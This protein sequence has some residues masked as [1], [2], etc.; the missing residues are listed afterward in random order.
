MPFLTDTLV[1]TF[2]NPRMGMRRILDLS[3]PRGGA[4]AALVLMAVASAMLIHLSIRLMAP[5]DQALALRL[6]GS[7]FMTAGVQLSVLFAAAFL[8]WQV[9]RW[10][11]GQGG[12]A[13]AVLAIAWLQAVM[14]ALQ[15]AQILLVLLLP[16]VALLVSYLAIGVF[17]V[18]LSNFVAEV[19]GFRSVGGVFLGVVLTL[20]AA[21]VILSFLLSL[22][23]DPEALSHGL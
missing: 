15:I 2:R 19:H 16:P 4:A 5:A 8:I 7:P 9:G 6:F 23:I 20:V 17:F 22:F 11:G 3:L 18:F 14:M 1:L 21:L 13:D 12:F 10:R